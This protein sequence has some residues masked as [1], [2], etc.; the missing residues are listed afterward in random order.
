MLILAIIL[1]IVLAS[2]VIA[3]FHLRKDTHFVTR[4]FM[5]HPNRTSICLIRNDKIVLAHNEDKLMPLASTVKI[6]IALEYANQVSKN[7]ISKNELVN[8]DELGKFYL[9]NTD[10]GAHKSWLTDLEQR[11]LIQ[12]NSVTIEEVTKGMIKFSSN[13]NAEYLIS[14]LGKENIDSYIKNE[15]L[16]HT[17]IYPF[18]SSLIVSARSPALD[19]EDLISESWKIHE[20][21]K[22][23][24]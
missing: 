7:V 22:K 24:L 18:V 19:T 14:R 11:Q 10:A 15:K 16:N 21:L 8:L 20:G 5:E 6:I 3:F 2:I 23:R 9:P 13:A 12:E 1:L 17:P 4:F